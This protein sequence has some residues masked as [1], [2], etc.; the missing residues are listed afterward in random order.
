M[1]VR[2][3]KAPGAENGRPL[4]V[5]DYSL[6][7]IREG[8]RVLRRLSAAGSIGNWKGWPLSRGA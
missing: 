1:N 7:H 5:E 6:W 4:E 3:G 8:R 2:C